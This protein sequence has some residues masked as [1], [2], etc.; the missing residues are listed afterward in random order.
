M[1]I[2]R[3]AAVA[4]A[5][6]LVMSG[7]S[8]GAS[9]GGGTTI[10]ISANSIKGGKNSSGAEWLTGYVIPKF[11]AM[12]KAKGKKVTVRFEGT[13][14]DDAPYKQKVALD[15]KTGGGADLISIDGIWVGEFA[16]AGYLKPLDQ[17]VGAKADSWDG[18]KQIPGPVQNIMSF[19]GKKYGLP[20]GTDGRVIFF[21]KQLFAKA[22]LPADW[23]PRSWDDIL[24]AG[25]KLKSLSGVTPIQLNAGTAMTEATTMQGVLPLLVGTG[26]EVFENGKWLGDTPQVR[27]VLNLYQ[28]VYGGGL[29]DPRL[30]QSAQGRDESFTRFAKGKVGI[31]LESDYFWR[32]VVNP[33]DGIDPMKDR[34]KDVGYALIPA[35]SAGKGVRGQDMV[36]MSGGSGW[37]VNPHTKDPS[38]VWDLLSFM[39]S[40]DAVKDEVQRT[41]VGISPRQDVN[42][43]MLAGDPLMNFIA[44]KVLPITDVRPGLAAYPQVSTALQKATG[45]V[46][47]GDSVDKTAKAYQQ[48]LTQAVGGAGNVTTG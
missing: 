21:N 42:A 47:A 20:T 35:Q 29:G 1:R 30:Q 3:M 19:G 11:T 2:T 32:S 27:D 39:G 24:A 13:G 8:G 28:Q 14:V 15:L 33:K 41:A 44:T 4:V 38:L 40:H 26:H 36:S 5:T 18:L 6:G 7:C 45:D 37:V 12:E 23:Q 16:Q 25:R 10:R 9:G 31:L 43:E 17:V 46:V 34:D 48:N 22:G